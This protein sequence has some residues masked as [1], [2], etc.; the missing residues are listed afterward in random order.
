MSQL[1][2]VQTDEGVWENY[3]GSILVAQLSEGEI[4]LSRLSDQL[5]SIRFSRFDRS[6]GALLE[7]WMSL[8]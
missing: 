3:D 2:L 8:V 5:L 7:S 1:G 6:I 4:L